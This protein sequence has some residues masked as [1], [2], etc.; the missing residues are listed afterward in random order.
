MVV[1]TAPGVP[2]LIHSRA[3]SSRSLAPL[4]M[5]SPC[6]MMSDSGCSATSARTLAAAAPRSLTKNRHT[7][8]CARRPWRPT[9]RSATFAVRPLGWM[10]LNTRSL[11]TRVLVASWKKTNSSILGPPSIRRAR[12][13]P[14]KAV[15]SPSSRARSIRRAGRFLRSAPWRNTTLRA[16]APAHR[17]DKGDAGGWARSRTRPCPVPLPSA[18]CRRR[19]ELATP[20]RPRHR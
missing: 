16:S 1:S 3:C 18:R 4:S 17:R 15:G 9:T 2:A 5:T 19:Q 11:T 14:A 10:T 8:L 20:A 12:T 7:R 6:D 13:E